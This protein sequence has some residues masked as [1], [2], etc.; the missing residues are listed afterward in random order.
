MIDLVKLSLIAG[1]GGNGRVSFRREK[2]VPKGGPDGGN[3]GNGGSIVFRGSRGMNT[4]RHLAG[5]REIVAQP[6]QPGGKKK[7]EGAK[8][9]DTIVEVPVGTVI[10]LVA[11]NG[12]SL[13]RRRRLGWG[14]AEFEERIK[15]SIIDESFAKNLDSSVK[16]ASF[17]SSKD[18]KEGLVPKLRRDDV[19]ISKYYLEKEGQGIPYLEPDEQSVAEE[20]ANIDFSVGSAMLDR[21]E[22][23]LEGGESATAASE[24]TIDQSRIKQF[25]FGQQTIPALRLIEITEVGQEVVVC[26]GGFGGRGNETFKG[27]SKTTPL[28]AE[29]GSQG[30]RKEVVVEL[31][32]LADVGLV[33]LPNAGKSTLLSKITK[34]NPKV[35]NYP[36]TTLEP[37]IGIL[38]TNFQGVKDLVVADIPGLIE[39]ASQGKGLGLDFLRHVENCSTLMFVLYLEEA[40]VFDESLSDKEKAQQL[41]NQYQI[42]KKE[43][44]EY[45][46]DLLKKPAILTLNKIDIYSSELIDA[47][48]NIF[49]EQDMILIPFS[50]VTGQNMDKVVEAMTKNFLAVK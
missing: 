14:E 3:G 46:P 36:F 10:W 26:Q 20:L 37:N 44:A 48:N 13:R 32:L 11:E 29:Y 30:E 34:A 9:P 24:S 5:V 40:L 49:S 2:F 50:G 38:N 31:R 39:G 42:L 35:A 4:L 22:T 45:H 25:I 21:D 23:E 6:G 33:G 1:N 47:I 28:E 7:M 41:W 16:K 12:V 43:L 18:N 17:N 8:A 15:E 19:E 27:P